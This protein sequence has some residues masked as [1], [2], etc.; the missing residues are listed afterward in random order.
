MGKSVAMK[1]YLASTLVYKGGYYLIIFSEGCI[2]NFKQKKLNSYVL[3][4]WASFS[5]G[6]YFELLI[7]ATYYRW[8]EF[9]HK[10]LFYVFQIFL[11]L[12]RDFMILVCFFSHSYGKSLILSWTFQCELLVKMVVMEA[13]ACIQIRMKLFILE[14]LHYWNRSRKSGSW[15]WRFQKWWQL[16]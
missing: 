7:F 13:K 5:Q 3:L 12:G 10:L 8:F 1:F 15:A 16:L 4:W 9:L 6:R 11:N 2:I 14:N